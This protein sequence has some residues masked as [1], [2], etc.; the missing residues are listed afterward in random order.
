MARALP[1]VLLG[2]AG[3]LIGAGAYVWL[4]PEPP[5][6]TPTLTVSDLDGR[7][8]TLAEYRGKVV[9]V[10]FWATWCP[11]CRK[12]IPMLI[13]AQADLADDG[14]QILGLALDDPE[15]VRRYAEQEGMNYPVFA[16]PAQIGPA[17]ARLGDTRG[18]LPFT[19]VI[20]RSGTVVEQHYGE[21]DR[22]ALDAILAPYL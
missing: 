22:V 3:L 21:L 11:P 15:P 20:D 2:I 17:L 16:D 19:V 10:N 13:E 7:A 12:E 1:L 8:H 6:A 5:P 4:E 14:L 9:V 18:A